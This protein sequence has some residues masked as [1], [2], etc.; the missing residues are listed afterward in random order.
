MKFHLSDIAHSAG[1]FGCSAY[2]S[3]HA[4]V[5]EITQ[6]F[7]HSSKTIPKRRLSSLS[8]RH[9]SF[10]RPSGSVEHLTYSCTVTRIGEVASFLYLTRFGTAYDQHILP[11][12]RCCHVMTLWWRHVIAWHHILTSSHSSLK[13]WRCVTFRWR[14]DVA[15]SLEQGNV[16]SWKRRLSIVTNVLLNTTQVWRMMLPT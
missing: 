8:S 11:N 12:K 5:K 10:T 2:E 1:T 14:D 7:L 6:S 3:F 9:W 4:E 13:C 15:F 16:G